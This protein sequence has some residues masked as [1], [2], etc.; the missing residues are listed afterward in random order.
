MDSRK[1]HL[2]GLFRWLCKKTKIKARKSR[3]A[4]RTSGTP[5]RQRDEAQPRSWAFYETIM[6]DELVKSR[7]FHFS[8][9]PAY[10][11]IQRIQ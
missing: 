2:F 5:Q 7:N 1:S 6:L 10:A 4:R 11:G 3:D 8:V 9:I